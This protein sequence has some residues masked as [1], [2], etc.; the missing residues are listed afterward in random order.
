ML[1]M[2]VSP[3]VQGQGLPK[4]PASA[5]AVPMEKPAPAG[6]VPRVVAAQAPSSGMVGRSGRGALLCGGW[7]R[8]GAAS[9]P[10]SF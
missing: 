3:A 5:V 2:A 8:M 9:W 7:M 1:L 10:R 6:V 4:P